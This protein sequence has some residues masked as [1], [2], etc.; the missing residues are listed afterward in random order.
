M[1]EEGK[2]MPIR[3]DDDR[4]EPYADAGLLEYIDR[5]RLYQVRLRRHRFLVMA[6]TALA[7]VAAAL[8]VSNV[9][10]LQRL[11]S[12]PTVPEPPAVATETPGIAPA[13]PVA[14]P[15]PP[16]TAE[17]PAVATERPAAATERPVTPPTPPAAASP[18]PAAVA[19]PPVEVPRPSSSP[20]AAVPAMPAPMTAR[21]GPAA[22]PE[23]S[24]RRTARWMVQTYGRLEAE[25]RAAR[26]AEFYGGADGAYWRRVL[27]NVRAEP[28][29]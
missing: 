25:N 28:E 21:S 26:V 15:E 10:L 7:V 13:P 27:L 1:R 12:R 20:V 5:R 19:P 2:S 16:A 29:R 11:A 8:A 17:P 22:E 9:V 24:A 3:D 4:E 18:G 14:T 23:D 6:V